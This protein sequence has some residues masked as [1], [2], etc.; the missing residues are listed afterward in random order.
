MAKRNNIVIK[1]RK[2]LLR[3]NKPVKLPD[4]VTWLKQPNLI[5]LMS[6]DLSKM[7]M[8]AVVVLIEALQED[9]NRKLSGAPYSQLF[10]FK[11]EDKD[12]VVKVSIP[13]RNFGVK[14]YSY[15][16]LR[17]AIKNLAKIPVEIDINHPETGA[18]TFNTTLL[19]AIIPIEG[20]QRKN[21]IF[22]IERE[23]AKCLVQIDIPNNLGYTKYV[24]EIALNA[25]SKYTIR[26]YMLIASWRDK[27]G[28]SMDVGKFK[29]WLQIED[30]EYPDWKDIE[31]RVLK[32]AEEE[33]HEKADCWFHYSPVYD[34][35][36][37]LQ[38]PY[39][40]D[41]KVIRTAKEE[42]V[43]LLTNMKQ[44]LYNVFI[45]LHLSSKQASEIRN[46]INIENYMF[47]RDKVFDLYSYIQ[48]N[49]STI[50]TI[51]EYFY[52]SMMK[53]IDELD[54]GE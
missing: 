5:T 10:L 16:D 4:N 1:E 8:R 37:S 31:K 6:C 43:K 26:M 2:P 17:E 29:H 25:R 34:Q 28:F 30:T 42:D 39:R 23:V 18:A 12:R 33:L 19:S 13:I 46:K 35:D 50:R 3:T 48:S 7:Q 51:P 53:F 24:K 49:I 40:I 38:T 41:F 11:D 32:T 44:S 9:I 27:G 52:S 45:N 36:V 20:S 47:V 54:S 14:P 22:R 15:P 21:V